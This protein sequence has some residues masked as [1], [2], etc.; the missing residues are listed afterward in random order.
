M[1]TPFY[2]KP[3]FWI[4]VIGIIAVVVLAVCLLNGPTKMDDEIPE[5]DNTPAT[6]T[7][8]SVEYEKIVN[9]YNEYMRDLYLRSKITHMGNY[10]VYDMN[11]DGMPELTYWT[12]DSMFFC[13]YEDEIVKTLD[14]IG[15][16]EGNI[17][18]LVNGAVLHRYDSMGITY[19]Y[20]TLDKDNVLTKTHFYYG[21]AGGPDYDCYEFNGE[22]VTMGE[23]YEL[24][25]DILAIPQTMD[26]GVKNL[27]Y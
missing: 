6:D 27:L 1:K 14:S 22:K 17:R 4:I 23:W 2:K 21:Y 20:V 25:E 8:D 9:V 7:I 10:A 3:S 12:K 11:K 24:T 16:K 5:T 26:I 15:I 19:C 13:I 18:Y